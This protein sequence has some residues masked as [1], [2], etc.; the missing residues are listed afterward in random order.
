MVA[1]ALLNEFSFGSV[2]RRERPLAP[3]IPYTRHV[4]DRVLRTRDGLVLTVLA[5]DGYAAETADMSEVNARLLARND[6]VRA[7]GNSRFALFSHVVRR[8]VTPDI[9]STFD[10][11]LCREIDARYRAGLSKTRMFVNE[12][13]LTLVRRPLQGQAGTF[14]TMLSGLLGRRDAAGASVADAA[15]LSE[16]HDAATAPA[17]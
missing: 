9:P 12:L 8:E 6:L 2:A 14:E 1:R 17:R 7:L 16:L 5:C 13:Y 11:A 4:D 3:H 10:N 15:A